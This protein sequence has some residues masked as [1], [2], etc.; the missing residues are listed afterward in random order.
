MGILSDVDIKKAMKKKEIIIEPMPPEESFGAGS[1]DIALSDVFY[2]RK[3][4]L[5]FK[6]VVDASTTTFEGFY[7]KVIADSVVI[8]PGECI[9]ALTHEKLMLAPNVCGW[10]QGRSRFARLGLTAHVASSFIQ[11]GAHNRQILEIVNLSPVPIRVS[12]GLRL[13]QIIFERTDSKAKV[14]YSKKGRFSKQ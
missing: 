1:V 13:C 14:P 10:I 12:K 9:L 6:K 4:S 5:F 8:K 7:N 3:K 11:P 2:V